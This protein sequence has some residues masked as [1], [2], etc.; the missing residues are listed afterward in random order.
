MSIYWYWL[1]N[2]PGIGAVTVDKLLQCFSSP[3]QIYEAK[4]QELKKILNPAQVTTLLER[5]DLDKIQKEWLGLEEKGIRFIH[6]DSEEYPERFR[7]FPDAPVGFY[8]KGKMPL[9]RTVSIAIVG[10]RNASAYGMEMA[11]YF[12]K[13]LAKAGVNIISGLA[14]GID[15]QAH[16]GALE[17]GGYTMGVLGC[18]I[19]IC[20]PK[21]NYALFERMQHSGG[22]FL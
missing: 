19:N 12:A 22:I 20:Y 18:G 9:E 3:K 7:V 5:K 10:A 11:L 15:K 16:I 6:R 21:E 14:Y 13:G 4:E 1:A 17:V 8:L 2:L